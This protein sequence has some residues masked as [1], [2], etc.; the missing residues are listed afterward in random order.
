MFE[1]LS[2]TFGVQL[3]IKI[4]SARHFFCTSLVIKS[5]SQSLEREVC[6]CLLARTFHHVFNVSGVLQYLRQAI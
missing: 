3:T 2:Y 6:F 5:Y 4:G 1:Y